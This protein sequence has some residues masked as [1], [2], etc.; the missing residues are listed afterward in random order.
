[1]PRETDLTA[2][3]ALWC[4]KL[5]IL[6]RLNVPM[7]IALE[8][9]A[10]EFAELCDMTL[11]LREVLRTGGSFSDAVNPHKAHFPRYARIC[12]VAG[13]HS[14]DLAGALSL[15]ADALFEHARVRPRKTPDFEEKLQGLQRE[16]DQPAVRVAERALQDAIM[17]DA[18][19]LHLIPG[20]EGGFGR[21]L[22]SGVWRRV[23]ELSPEL[24]PAV[25]RRLKAMA[26]IPYWIQ[27][28]AMGKITVNHNDS[29]WDFAVRAIPVEGTEQGRLEMTLTARDEPDETA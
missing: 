12:I 9:L 22:V 13:E 1:M 28:P 6:L 21:V 29:V 5:A 3:T 8:V 15:L 11:Q 20:D 26:N 24:F 16:A 7:L 25:V 10:E 14:G 27:E 18:A 4:R 19:E 2:E 17:A 23:S